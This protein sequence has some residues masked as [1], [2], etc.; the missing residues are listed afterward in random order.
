VGATIK[1]SGKEG[2]RSIWVKEVNISFNSGKQG[3]CR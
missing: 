2:D 3:Q 1:V